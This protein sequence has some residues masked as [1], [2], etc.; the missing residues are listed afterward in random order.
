MGDTVGKPRYGGA[1]GG[2][3]SDGE[4]IRSLVGNKVLGMQQAGCRERPWPNSETES[5][6]K[7]YHELGVSGRVCY[8]LIARSGPTLQNSIDCSLP[9]SSVHGISQAGI[10]A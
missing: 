3:W 7:R 6:D 5:P 10:L 2:Y 1:Q 9:G 4:G 8:C